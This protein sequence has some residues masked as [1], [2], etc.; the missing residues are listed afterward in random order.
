[1]AL[2]RITFAARAAGNAASLAGPVRRAM[3]QSAPGVTVGAMETQ[4]ERKGR[5]SRAGRML[6]AVYLLLGL[7]A[8]AQAAFGLYGTVSHFVNRR[9]AEIGVRI[10][11]G[12][13]TSD[14]LRLVIRQA[15]TPVVIGLLLGLACSPIVAHVMWAA[16]LTNEAPWAELL[17]MAALISLVMLSAF[18]VAAMPVRRV[19]RLDPSTALRHE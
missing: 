18:A 4:A 5:G 6:T 2:S 16:R 1:M 13:R 15:L 3:R 9:T 11:L 19:S 8:T 14:V 17:A 12:A 10:V 7:L